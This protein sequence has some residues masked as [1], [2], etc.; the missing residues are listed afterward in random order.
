MENK[1][2]RLKDFN[3]NSLNAVNA[4]MLSN[5]SLSDMSSENVRFMCCIS[6]VL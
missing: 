3:V 5:E 6:L 4:K 2:D 1:P